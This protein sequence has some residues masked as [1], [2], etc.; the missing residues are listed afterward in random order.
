MA[1]HEKLLQTLNKLGMEGLRYFIP[2]AQYATYSDST[3][4]SSAE[5]MTKDA[6][7]GSP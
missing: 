7:E 6:T 5:N 2:T 1:A 3:R 4:A